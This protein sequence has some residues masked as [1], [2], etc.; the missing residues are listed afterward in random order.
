MKYKLLS[1][2]LILLFQIIL[3]GCSE[4]IDKNSELRI[5]IEKLRNE[6][7]LTKKSI[8]I[9]KLRDELEKSKNISNIINRSDSKSNIEPTLNPSTINKKSIE[10]KEIQPNNIQVIPKKLI[11]P[12]VT[13]VDEIETIYIPTSIPRIYTTNTP[14]ITPT[15][16][17]TVTPPPTSTPD[18]RTRYTVSASNLINEF[19]TNLFST[20]DKYKETFLTV[21]G[22][23]MAIGMEDFREEKWIEIGSGIGSD[24]RNV[25]CEVTYQYGL[26][27]NVELGNNISIE[28]EFYKSNAVSI[29]LKNCKVVFIE[30]ENEP[31][32]IPK[33]ATSTPSPIHNIPEQSIPAPVFGATSTPTPTPTL[34][35]TPTPTPNRVFR[36]ANPIEITNPSLYQ[37]GRTFVA[38]GIPGIPV[39]DNDLDGDLTDEVIAVVGPESTSNFQVNGFN[40]E[41][42]CSNCNN[43]ISFPV[44]SCAN[45]D[46]DTNNSSSPMVTIYI[47]GNGI[48]ENDYISWGYWSIE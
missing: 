18:P 45:G 46:S 6:I 23:T 21:S 48:S 19:D 15:I 33:L 13:P 11:E 32:Y 8:E 47:N 10:E 40:A 14:T 16:I 30:I 17:P 38:S 4:N 34:T 37:S 7:E 2:N 35:P 12:A 3:I 39:I 28:G 26:N 22:F 9:E 27:G 41:I 44:V 1:F 42:I 20:I 29:Y 5:E 25:R 36:M 24:S 43:D 31:L